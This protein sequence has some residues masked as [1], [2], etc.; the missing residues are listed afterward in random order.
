[1]DPPVSESL[2]SLAH[3]FIVLRPGESY[4]F[5]R[6]AVLTRNAVR[7]ELIP[8]IIQKKKNPMAYPSVIDRILPGA[9]SSA[10]S[11]GSKTAKNNMVAMDA[12]R[13]EIQPQVATACLLRLHC[14]SLGVVSTMVRLLMPDLP[15]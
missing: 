2:M 9:T 11:S 1:M 5:L 8:Q 7:A 12:L 14:F 6:G 15:D 13:K 10:R 3:R 4:W